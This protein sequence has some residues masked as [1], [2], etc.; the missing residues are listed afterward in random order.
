MDSASDQDRDQDALDMQRLAAGKDSALN[1]LMARYS[2]RLFHFL[3]RELQNESEAA[4]LAEETFVRVYQ[5]R[6]R[7]DPSRK[8]STWLYAIALNLVRDRL[9]WRARH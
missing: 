2:Q 3:V 6:Q 4:D 9:R 8:F 7:F 1:E 5:S